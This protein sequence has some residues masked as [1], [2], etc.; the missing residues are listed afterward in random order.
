MEDIKVIEGGLGVDDRGTVSFVNTFDFKGVKRFY[1]IENFSKDVIRAFHG[2]AKEA[3]YVYVAKGTIILAAVPMTDTK[4][5]DP[6]AKVSRYVLSSRKPT[7]VYI[8]AGYANGFRC[9]EDD[10]QILFFSTSTLEE[11]K[12]DDYRFPA[13]YWG[14]QIWEVEN[15]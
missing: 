7:I 11:S 9:L 3:K 14:A 5:P 1:K 2:H 13:D 8:P 10:S 15:R 4:T 6:K 12:G